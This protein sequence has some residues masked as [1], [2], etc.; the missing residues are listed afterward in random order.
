[1][2]IP[3]GLLRFYSRQS[4]NIMSWFDFIVQERGDRIARLFTRT[5]EARPSCDGGYR[6]RA[7]FFFFKNT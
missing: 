5:V 3:G 1:M 4:E 7:L 2:E 6:F